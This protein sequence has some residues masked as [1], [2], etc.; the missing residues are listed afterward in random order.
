MLQGTLF[1]D[2]MMPEE[3]QK[4]KRGLVDLEETFLRENSGAQ[5]QR[6]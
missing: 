4:I 3:M 6:V 5:I 1:H 2:R